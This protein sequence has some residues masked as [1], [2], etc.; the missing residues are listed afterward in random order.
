MRFSILERDG[1]PSNPSH[2]FLT[3]GASGGAAVIL[4]M[5]IAGPS[6]GV[7]IPIPQYPLYTPTLAQRRGTPIPYYLDETH[8]W[9]T[10]PTP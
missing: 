8:G 10:D 1:Y 2:I 6:S 4:N 9:S 5:L 3:A 7:L